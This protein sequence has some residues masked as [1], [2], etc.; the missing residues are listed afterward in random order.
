MRRFI[1]AM[2]LLVI[3]LGQAAAGSAQSNPDKTP[4][5]RD[6]S[7]IRKQVETLRGK[8]FL[9]AVPVYR[10]SE[11]ELRLISERELDKDFPGPKLRSYEELLAWLDMVPP[12]TDLKKAYGDFLVDQLAGLYDSDTKEMC[13]PSIA[14]GGVSTGRESMQTKLQVQPGQMEGLVLAHEFT[15]ALEDQYWPIDDPKDHDLTLSTDRGTA[16]DVLVEGSATREMVECVPA[17]WGHRSPTGYFLLWNLIHSG[18]GELVLKY[19]LGRAWKSREALVAGVP[20]A[21]A[22]REAMPYSFGYTFCVGVVR[23]WGLDGLDYFY[24][25]PPV[26]TTQLM[27]PKK[28]W[29]WRD[30]PVQIDLPE[31]LP[32]GW[33]KTSVDSL[34]ESGMAVLFG[35]QFINLNRGLE[36]ARG[37]DGDHAALFEGPAGHRLLLWASSWNSTN[38]A[39]RFVSAWVHERQLVH[40]AVAST[41]KRNRIEW[42][43]RDGRV[44]QIQRDGKRVILLETDDPETFQDLDEYARDVRFNEPL[45]DAI[46]A[47][48]N[49]PLRRFNPVWSWQKD[50]DYVVRRSLG[51]LLTRHDRNSVGAADRLLLGALAESR[52]TSSFHKWEA[53]GGLLARHESEARRGTTKTTVLPWGLLASHCAARLPESPDKVISRTSVV[54]GLGASVTKDGAGGAWLRVLPFGLLLRHSNDAEHSSTLI[55][56]TG[57]T[58]WTSTDASGS[59]AR[60]RLFAIPLWTVHASRMRS[61]TSSLKRE[62]AAA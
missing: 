52:R 29:E 35:C 58:R 9:Q 55:L 51:G 62:G 33:K 7:D 56:G 39:G 11:R 61:A 15:H 6:F 59:K 14:R 47:A 3:G 12:Q 38:A 40:R 10:I 22:R 25:H 13:L 43:I 20:D 30:F 23:Q 19:E 50:G 34:G 21:L 17:Q 36:L 42:R 18:L 16:H 28:A 45:A 48:A 44:G 49:R 24:N 27:H 26:S 60:F 31:I 57:L 5:T 8:T 46:R 37:W 2:A 54:W 53:G 4:S 1:P 32:R 41:T